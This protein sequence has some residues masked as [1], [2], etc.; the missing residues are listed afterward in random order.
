MARYGGSWESDQDE[1]RVAGDGHAYAEFG[2]QEFRCP[3]VR[4]EDVQRPDVELPDVRLD[5]RF[6]GVRYAGL[7]VAC[8]DVGCS[9]DR[10]NLGREDGQDH[11]RHPA[12]AVG[13]ACRYGQRDRRRRS[14][15]RA[16]PAREGHAHPGARHALCR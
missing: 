4:C 6:A 8:E 13:G 12:E 2:H 15:P 5:V 3:S 14:G 16:E 10:G 9:E 7:D 11:D 1:N